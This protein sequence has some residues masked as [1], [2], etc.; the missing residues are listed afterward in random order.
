MSY[1]VTYKIVDRGIIEVFGP[2][3]LSSIITR[4]ATYISKLQTGYLYH[5][6]LI[7]LIGS[8]FILGFRQFWIIFGDLFDF[9]IFIIKSSIRLSNM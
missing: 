6:T 8:T 3:G 5:I 1:T 9:R 7:M 2:M 4:K